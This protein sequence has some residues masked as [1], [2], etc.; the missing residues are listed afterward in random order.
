MLR[1]KA[2]PA[3]KKELEVL[4]EF[5]KSN[6]F[7]GESLAL[8]DV[9][10]WSERQSEKLFGFEEEELRPYFALPNVLSGLFGLCSRIFDVRIEEAKGDAPVWH[11][12][13]RIEPGGRR[14]HDHRGLPCGRRRILRLPPARISV[15]CG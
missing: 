7:D 8:W 15:A 2:L 10:Y 9:P 3:A 11:V 12:C 6:G 13:Y 14:Q 5:A 1:E 4:T